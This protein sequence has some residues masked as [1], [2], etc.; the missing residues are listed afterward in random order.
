MNNIWTLEDQK[1][2]DWSNLEEGIPE[3]PAPKPDIETK[4]VDITPEKKTYIPEAGDKKP[5]ETRKEEGFS[6]AEPVNIYEPGFRSEVKDA[7]IKYWKEKR[8][9]R[10]HLDSLRVKLGFKR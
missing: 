4:L 5:F 10:D 9:R 2:V 3:A 7:L 6:M 1:D 8:E